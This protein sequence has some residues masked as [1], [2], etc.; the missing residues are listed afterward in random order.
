[1][2]RAERHHLKEH[3]IDRLASQAREAVEGRRRE[4][5]IGISAVVI[6]GAVVLGY[7]TLRERTQSGAH[8]ML[9]DAMTVA[10]TRV[11][12]PIAPGTPGAGP[13][14]PSERERSQ[15]AVTKFK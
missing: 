3:V 7:I 4:L 9:A 13:S 11:G 1:M 2:K 6:I 10:E 15:A 14:F 5:T 12:A 8:T